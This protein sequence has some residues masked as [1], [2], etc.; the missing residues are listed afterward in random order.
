[1]LFPLRMRPPWS[2]SELIFPSNGCTNWAKLPHFSY[3]ISLVG[4][5]DW[6]AYLLRLLASINALF[7]HKFPFTWRARQ[8]SPIN[9]A[10][11]QN[12]FWA[13]HYSHRICGLFNWNRNRSRAKLTLALKRAITLNRWIN[14]YSIL[15][16]DQRLSDFV[17]ACASDMNKFKSNA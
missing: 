14:N 10:F 12:Q 2:H 11:A 5:G 15:N 1:M 9:E 7:S 3:L 6:R 16:K 8:L 13:E 4:D 17:C